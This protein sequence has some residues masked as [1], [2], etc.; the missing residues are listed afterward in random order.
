M[1]FTHWFE[2]KVELIPRSISLHE[3]VIFAKLAE[4]ILSTQS[5]FET[6]ETAKCFWVSLGLSSKPIPETRPSQLNLIGGFCALLQ[7]LW[8]LKY[9][10]HCLYSFYQY[11]EDGQVFFTWFHTVRY[12]NS[13]Q[14]WSVLIASASTYHLEYVSMSWW[15]WVV[16]SALRLIYFQGLLVNNDLLLLPLYPLFLFCFLCLCLMF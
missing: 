7:K 11:T 6:S 8:N 9:F 15:L 2:K 1:N 3:F 14:L 10:L 4:N 16:N 13:E 12:V 5:P